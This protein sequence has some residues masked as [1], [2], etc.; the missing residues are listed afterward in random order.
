MKPNGRQQA[1]ARWWPTSPPA[2][3]PSGPASRQQARANSLNLAPSVSSTSRSYTRE[4]ASSP[5]VPALLELAKL[6]HWAKQCNSTFLLVKAKRSHYCWIQ[7]YSAIIRDLHDCARW[8]L[9]SPP[10]RATSGPVSKQLVRANILIPAPSVFPTSSSYTKEVALNSSPT[11]PAFI[12]LAKLGHSA[13]RCNSTFLLVE[14]K[15][16]HYLLNPT[17]WLWSNYTWP[18]WLCSQS[19]C[20]STHPSQSKP[21]LRTRWAAL[22]PLRRCVVQISKSPPLNFPNQES[23]IQIHQ[24]WLS[25]RSP[26]SS[27]YS[28]LISILAQSRASSYSESQDGPLKNSQSTDT[29]SEIIGNPESGFLICSGNYEYSSSALETMRIP[30]QIQNETVPCSTSEIIHWISSI[31][32]DWAR[33]LQSDQ[34]EKFPHW[35]FYQDNWSLVQR[36]SH[37]HTQNTRVSTTSICETSSSPL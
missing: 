34:P 3:T 4:V 7:Q 35:E 21:P 15:P 2:R 32:K 14:G 17:I 23:P 26:L 10:P 16:S 9:T 27:S 18:V 5:Q 28:C 22:F 20:E 33:Q 24:A 6:W 8:W 1:C 30:A 31:R 36:P 12:E 37:A 25:S 19:T 29:A 11:V 13:E